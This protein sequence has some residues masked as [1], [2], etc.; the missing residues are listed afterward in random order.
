MA[1]V[2]DEEP[3]H[4]QPGYLEQS[5]SARAKACTTGSAE[6]IA[7]ALESMAAL[8]DQPIAMTVDEWFGVGPDGA[9]WQGDAAIRTTQPTAPAWFL[10]AAGGVR[11]NSGKP[12][13]VYP[14]VAWLVQNG[15]VPGDVL[16]FADDNTDKDHRSTDRVPRCWL[17]LQRLRHLRPNSHCG[18]MPLLITA[19]VF[20]R[21][22]STWQLRSSWRSS[23]ERA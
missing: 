16:V 3:A 18:P 13:Y 19:T 11:P 15:A 5:G 9:R 14:W 23:G 2:L 20:R 12:P 21:T 1:C 17:R 10:D 8:W 4:T 7:A 6:R 22:W